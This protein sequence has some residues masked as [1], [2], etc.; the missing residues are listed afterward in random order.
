MIAANWGTGQVLL[1]ILWFFL[2]FVEVW[3]MITIFIDLFRRHDIK[4][5]LKALWVL[6]VIVVPLI[7][8]L[9]YLVIYG[10]EMRVHAQHAA[11]DQD[12]AFRAYVREAAGSPSTPSPATDL[13]HLQD[14][15]ER[16]VLTEDEFER[17]KT[18]IVNGGS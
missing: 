9:L 13:M 10:N 17:L 18:R 12:R 1:D 4:G 2:F 14:L 6:L 3:L 15:R 16:G 7:G 8:I 5:W 11:A